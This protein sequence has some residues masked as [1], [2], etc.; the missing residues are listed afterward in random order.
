MIRLLHDKPVAQEL[1][2]GA[3]LFSHSFVAEGFEVAH[4][5]ELDKAAAA[6]YRANLGDH[7]EVADVR[8]AEPSGHCDL[9]IAGPPCQ[10]FSTLGK[11]NENDPRNQLS[12]EVVRWA[13]VLQPKAVVIENVAAFLASPVWQRLASSFEQLGYD[14]TSMVLNAYDMGAPQVRLRSFTIASKI[15]CPVIRRAIK[16]VQTVRE[17]WQGL[18]STPDGK[19]NH[20]APAPSSLALARMQV[21]PLG[22]D[23]RDVLRTAPHLAPPSWNRVSGEVTDVWGRLKWDQPSNTLRTA[24]QNPS[25]GRYIHP[26]QNRVIS[27]REA[28]RLHTIPDSWTFCGLPTQVA[29]QI[30]NSVPPALGRA[31]ARSVRAL[32]D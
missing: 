22:G 20:Y 9:L 21:I 24:L 3:G 25:K 29:R 6:T 7:M 28:A 16:S 10:G 26:D 19:N 15:G 30:G 31:I 8:H 12:M 32:F 13:K 18:P 5:V 27:L 11:Q 1:F 23:K 2:A 17:A 4:A 14:V